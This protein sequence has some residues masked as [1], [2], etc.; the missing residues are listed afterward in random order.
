MSREILCLAL[1]SKLAVAYASVRWAEPL[2]A[3]L[4]LAPLD[5]ALLHGIER[6][7]GAAVVVSGV[8]GIAC[9]AQLYAV[10]RRTWWKLWSSGSKIFGTALVLGLGFTLAVS[11]AAAYV[12]GIGAPAQLGVLCL[13]LVLASTL[14]LAGEASVFGHLREAAAS[15]LKRTALLLRGALARWTNLR[16]ALGVLGGVLMPLVVGS[17]LGP[18]AGLGTLAVAALGCACLIAG[19]LLERSL[20]FMAVAPPKMP[21]AVGK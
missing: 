18:H 19:E 1:F 2:F 20:F 4:G 3:I 10:T 14:K 13:G 8:A 9:S 15:D 5:P 6:G 7:L 21:G 11:L 17:W 16:F 12:S